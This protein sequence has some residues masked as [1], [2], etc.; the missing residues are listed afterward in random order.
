MK[1]LTQ[2]ES[3]INAFN[4]LFQI[5]DYVEVKRDNGSVEI[6]TVKYPATILG[7]HTAVGWFNEI[8]GCYDLDRVII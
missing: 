7:G 4:D 2:L 3:Q 6:W 8:Y 1:T 5:G